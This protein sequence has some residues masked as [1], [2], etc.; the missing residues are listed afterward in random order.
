M[1]K[2]K[3]SISN[4]FKSRAQIRKTFHTG[5]DMKCPKKYVKNDLVM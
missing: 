5:A 2:S 4:G 3:I 1:A